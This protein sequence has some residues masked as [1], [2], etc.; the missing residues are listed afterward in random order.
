MKQSK[1]LSL[2]R[3]PSSPSPSTRPRSSLPLSCGR[4]SGRTTRRLTAHKAGVAGVNVVRQSAAAH[5]LAQEIRRLFKQR[6]LAHTP[7]VLPGERHGRWGRRRGA[8]Q[9]QRAAG[10]DAA[11]ERGIERG[12]GESQRRLTDTDKKGSRLS[13]PLYS[14]SV[15]WRLHCMCVCV[16]VCVCVCYYCRSSHGH[17]AS[18]RSKKD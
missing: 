14:L 5:V 7:C 11:D 3:S 12:E 16:H 15:F 1:R 10:S 17:C 6:P 13:F 2:S 4:L 8:A 18:A 9:W